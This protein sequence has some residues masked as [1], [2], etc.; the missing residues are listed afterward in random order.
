MKNAAVL[1]ACGVL[2]SPVC[3]AVP[4][5]ENLA[6]NLGFE[7]KGAW[8]LP[9][10]FSISD[11]QPRSGA[12]C[13]KL[14]NS[15]AKK[16]L[17][18]GAHPKLIPGHSYEFEAWLRTKDVKGGD[19]G[20]ATICIE[21]SGADGKYLGGCYPHGLHGTHAEWTRVF[22]CT[23][24]IPTNA[25][26]FSVSCYMRR[27][28]TGTAWWDDV[29]IREYRP[30]VVEMLTSDRYRDQADGGRVTVRA[31]LA[32]AEN[33]LD[34]AAVRAELAVLAADGKCAATGKQIRLTGDAATLEFD[35]MPLAPGAY[36]LRCT[37]RD[38]AGAEVDHADLPFKRVAA[39]PPR[40]AF[41]DEHRRLILD[42]QPFF[43]LGTYWG[44]VKPE[45][46]A[47]YAK[48]PFN[49][50]MPYADIGRAGADLAWSN[51]IRVIYSVKD[52]Y[53]CLRKTLKDSAA[54]RQTIAQRVAS[55]KDHPG[56]IAWY[57]NDELPLTMRDELVAHRQWLEELDPG[58]PTWAVLYQVGQLRGY[59]P[60]CDV[61]GTDPYPIGRKPPV[62]ARDWTR[63]TREASL[64]AHAVW[65]VP[66]IF[67]WNSYH[68]S[69]D[70][71][72][73]QHSP[74]LAEMR[75]MA[76]SCL[77]EGANGLIFYSWF[78]LLKMDKPKTV[79][80]HTPAREPF[81]ERW[82]DVTAMAGEIRDFIPILLSIEPA[83]QPQVTA[84]ADCAWR[85]LAKDG[86]TW[87]IAVNNH[88]HA[89]AAMTFHFAAPFARAT[90]RFPG[91]QPEGSGADWKLTLPPLGVQCLK[92]EK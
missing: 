43:P 87:L 64:G 63:S 71:V 18:A 60:T 21:W 38:A 80:G 49:C 27:G 62:M 1:L 70:K 55:L 34:A 84:P 32:L 82:R 11:E 25:A 44:T 54:A 33:L 76:W 37:V 86:A 30:P 22:E 10:Q 73:P 46:M 89:A 42:G 36:T 39:S 23:G 35:A 66:Q 20:G 52:L 83:A 77:A 26:R 91:A 47:I 7:E 57:I 29:A 15:D 53:P 14:E 17:L 40:K 51:G 41:I 65:M 61:L 50:L 3:R 68:K 85:A 92:L 58:R 16:Y 19:N 9:K 5:P 74:T 88:E 75:A 31:G 8:S 79:D 59:V 78:D 90:A 4:A 13:L 72:V 69:G 28:A 45:E 56:I 81:E 2:L 6:P 12:H 24:R 67:D 48:S